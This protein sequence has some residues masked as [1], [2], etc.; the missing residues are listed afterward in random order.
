[1]GR[2]I[3]LLALVLAAC[4]SRPATPANPAA[5]EPT[6]REIP[7]TVDGIPKT[8]TERLPTGELGTIHRYGSAD[9]RPDV[10]VYPTTGWSDVAG[11]TDEFLQTLA[12]Y[13]SRGEFDSYQVLLKQPI[14]VAGFPGHEVVLKFTRRGQPSDSYFSLVRLPNEYVKFRISQP[15]EAKSVEKARSFMNSWIAAYTGTASK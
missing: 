10:Y 11:Q 15:P 3:P 5:P 9:F 2:T 1:M 4:A 8:K 7:A 14:T 12:I 13:R 6:A